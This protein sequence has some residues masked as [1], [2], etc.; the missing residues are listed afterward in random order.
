M[1]TVGFIGSGM[2]GS[3]VA[4]LAIAAGH[5]VLLSNSRGPETLQDLVVELGP[6]ARAATREEAAAMANFVVVAI[7]VR[8][9]PE[10]SAVPLAGKTVM[11]TGNHYAARDGQIAELD[12][13]TLTSS[14]YLQRQIPGAEVV[15][16]FNNIFFKHLLN[17]ARPA[18][19]D[20]RSYL[21]IAGDSEWAKATVTQF[22]D[23]IGYGAVDAGPLAESWRQEPGTPVYGAPYGSFDDE[24]G[25]PAGAEVIRAALAAA[26]R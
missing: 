7:P 18:H 2:I 23:S 24:K 20:D 8:A 12:A 16:V 5:D 10:V 26:T 19:A 14:E 17:L 9:Y 15:K 6:R 11:D 3:A 21:P 4:R 25:T 1:A 13:K 22:L